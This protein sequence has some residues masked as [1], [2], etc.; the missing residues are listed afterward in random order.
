VV[1]DLQ[2]QAHQQAAALG[3]AELAP[4][5]S[6]HWRA[7]RTAVDVFGVPRW[8]VVVRL[9][10]GRVDDGQGALDDERTGRRCR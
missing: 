8:I 7:A 10:V 2:R 5:P 4:R 9:A 1:G 6:K 3:G